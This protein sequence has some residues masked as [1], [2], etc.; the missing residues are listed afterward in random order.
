M[1]KLKSRQKTRSKKFKV[2][3]HYKNS[4]KPAYSRHR[5]ADPLELDSE[6][7]YAIAK[8]RLVLDNPAPVSKAFLPSD[9]LPTIKFN[10]KQLARA[11]A[12]LAKL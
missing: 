2:G 9:N 1:A 11:T 4:R 6:N 7:N 12:I 3:I 8:L 5:T 10:R